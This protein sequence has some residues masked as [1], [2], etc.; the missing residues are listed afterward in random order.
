MTTI[1]HKRGIGV[2][3]VD[4]L[5]AG[6]I[7]IDTS[8]GIAYTKNN[9][10]EI[11]PVGGDFV[12]YE[13]PVANEW[14]AVRTT[15]FGTSA[16]IT[17]DGVAVGFNEIGITNGGG[18]GSVSISSLNGPNGES[19]S[20]TA[21]NNWESNVPI[22]MTVSGSGE[23]SQY[24]QY[25]DKFLFDGAP[26]Q[27]PDF[28]DADGNS[29]VGSGGDS[30]WTEVPENDTSPYRW[31][32]L[33]DQATGDDEYGFVIQY[34]TAKKDPENP[35]PD[36]PNGPW[37]RAKM[38][39]R[40]ILANKGKFHTANI[41]TLVA[42][43]LQVLEQQVLGGIQILG[44]NQERPYESLDEK[45]IQ[46]ALTVGHETLGRTIVIDKEG[47]IRA[48][49]FTDLD[50]NSIVSDVSNPMSTDSLNQCYEEEWGIIGEGFE[51][52]TENITTNR[53]WKHIF[54]DQY[55]VASSAD[56][57]KPVFRLT[58]VGGASAHFNCAV[59]AT[60]FLD[61][62]GNS[63]IGAGGGGGID[64]P[65]ADE[66]YA[67]LA[68]PDGW[69][70]FNGGVGQSEWLYKRS[71][72]DAMCWE[73]KKGHNTMAYQQTITAGFENTAAA[74]YDIVIGNQNYDMGAMT[75]GYNILI[76]TNN[77][78][79][80]IDGAIAI[81]KDHFLSTGD[82][83][84]IGFAIGEGNTV[85][86]SGIAIGR[87]VSARSGQVIIGEKQVSFAD[88]LVEAFTALQAA[89]ADEDTVQGLK[90]ALTNSLGGLIE[91]FEQKAR[92][93][94]LQRMSAEEAEAAGQSA[95]ARLEEKA[96]A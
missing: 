30:I 57:D 40:E 93:E 22:D 28:L 48:R 74:K 46:Y 95:R 75:T 10:G 2:P 17:E 33:T 73:G 3:A 63:I 12:P 61:A 51:F 90:S 96:N 45:S 14:M 55:V 53:F 86:G 15:D 65:E 84:V 9:S 11:V 91:K 25:P 38:R 20:I 66:G 13:E 79:V 64:F 77:R 58:A 37:D 21:A 47:I 92:V 87:N 35:D 72:S 27:A 60:D 80:G 62:D 8:T 88:D 6:E 42:G 83:N 5:T 94:P 89:V 70:K 29:I 16:A 52:R 49:D 85:E 43:D 44:A 81:G 78:C 18:G 54:Q 67:F 50:G 34:S 59:Q 76:G 26:V 19:V 7:A 4:D 1:V 39:L 71:G 82:E 68:T 36:F 69:V 24:V 41:D 32:T 23:T 31:V 56:P